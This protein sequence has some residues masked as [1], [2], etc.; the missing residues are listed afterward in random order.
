[1]KYLRLYAGPDGETHF[2]DVEIPVGPLGGRDSTGHAWPA[3]E[4]I[5]LAPRTDSRVL[6]NWHNAPARQFVVILSGEAEYEASD[7]EVRRLGPGGVMLVED[8]TGKGHKARH[9]GERTAMHIPL[10]DR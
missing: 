6:D 2:E 5:M 9:A 1:M 3:S 4:V 10:A 8:T 7:G